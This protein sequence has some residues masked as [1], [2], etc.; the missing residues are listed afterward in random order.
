MASK[1]RFTFMFAKRID[2]PTLRFGIKESTGGIGADFSLLDKRLEIRTD[3]F[4][5]QANIFPRF[6]VEAALNFF[7]YLYLVGGIDDILNS[8]LG[9]RAAG[10][11]TSSAPSCAST[12][13]TSRRC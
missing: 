11:T 9:W 12:T 4:D 5:A 13:T 8:E 3:L 6:K 1:F 2:W 10:A 7:Q